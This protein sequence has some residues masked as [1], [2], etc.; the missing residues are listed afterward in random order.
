MENRRFVDQDKQLELVEL[1]ERRNTRINILKLINKKLATL[2]SLNLNL[3][4]FKLC[5]L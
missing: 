5:F 4:A 2:T 1:E 3:K